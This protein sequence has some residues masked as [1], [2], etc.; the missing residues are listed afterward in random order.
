M[1]LEK[2]AKQIA[3]G[4]AY[5]A[6]NNF[7]HRDLACRNCLVDKK[8]RVKI[9]DF[10]MARNMYGRHYYRVSTYISLHLCYMKLLLTHLYIT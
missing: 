8:L 9:S 7:V 1:Q 3:S 6:D 10:G 4:L 5:L 2:V